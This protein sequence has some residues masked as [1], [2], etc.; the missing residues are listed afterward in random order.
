MLV[1]LRGAS[2]ASL[3]SG[4]HRPSASVTSWAT[5]HVAPNFNNSDA[6]ARWWEGTNGVGCT[7]QNVAHGCRRQCALCAAVC[8]ETWRYAITMSS[9]SSDCCSS[10]LTQ[11]RLL[12]GCSMRSQCRPTLPG[13]RRARSRLP[14]LTVWDMGRAT[15]RAPSGAKS[16]RS[17]LCPADTDDD[18]VAVAV[19]VALIG[20]AG[21]GDT[22][23]LLLFA[24]TTTAA[25][26][27]AVDG[28]VEVAMAA[29]HSQ[30]WNVTTSTRIGSS[31]QFHQVST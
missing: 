20:G 22:G 9:T 29:T 18:G 11:P 24:S 26:S 15:A 12:W 28:G 23:L 27:A 16:G 8:G 10:R 17:A 6:C 13:L 4:S 14:G 19:A 3:Y 21:G 25:L 2:K 31:G 7:C 1:L 30:R 5:R